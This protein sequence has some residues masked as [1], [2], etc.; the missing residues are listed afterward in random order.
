MKVLF[1]CLN[2]ERFCFFFTFIF[3]NEL[4]M[5]YTFVRIF[6]YQ[7]LEIL[8]NSFCV[9]CNNLHIQFFQLRKTFLFAAHTKCRA[10]RQ[11]LLKRLRSLIYS[12]LD[13]ASLVK[14]STKRSYLKELD[15]IYN[16][17]LRLVLGAF[18]TF[19]VE[20]HE[21]LLKLKC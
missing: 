14:R 17:G 4:Q 9:I 15:S 16:E 18:R 5:V 3:A 10:D 7:H 12:Q 1:V 11:T 21:A 13:S 2:C 6:V 19:L 8:S 20:V